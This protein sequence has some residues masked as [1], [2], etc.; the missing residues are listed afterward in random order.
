MHEEF[1]SNNPFSMSLYLIPSIILDIF[2]IFTIELSYSDGLSLDIRIIFIGFLYPDYH[3]NILIT[4]LLTLFIYYPSET[5]NLSN[6]SLNNLS[7]I[8]IFYQYH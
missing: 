6:I 7:G 5:C 2:I 4:L 8:S 3:K 1:A